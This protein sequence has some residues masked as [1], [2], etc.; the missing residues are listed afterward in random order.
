MHSSLNDSNSMMRPID[1]EHP[2]VAQSHLKHEHLK[3]LNLWANSQQPV[4]ATQLHCTTG[5]FFRSRAK[6]SAMWFTWSGANLVYQQLSSAWFSLTWLSI[7]T[8]TLRTCKSALN[9]NRTT[10]NSN[11]ENQIEISRMIIE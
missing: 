4:R 3:H 2:E 1:F 5:K 11:R 9:W 6:A 10:I 8:H 7:S